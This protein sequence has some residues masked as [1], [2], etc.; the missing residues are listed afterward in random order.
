MHVRGR[1]NGELID[2]WVREL[3]RDDAE[4]RG[5]EQ[6]LRGDVALED[7]VALHVVAECGACGRVGAAAEN[8]CA[9]CGRE[10]PKW[11]TA[12]RKETAAGNTL[13]GELTTIQPP[14]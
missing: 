13:V 6:A 2:E 12:P 5:L 4:L 3:D 1:W 14:A 11:G 10:L 9:G 8:F 7:L